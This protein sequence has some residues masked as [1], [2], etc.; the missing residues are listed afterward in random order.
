MH[1]LE[2]PPVENCPLNGE[3]KKRHQDHLFL[4]PDDRHDMDQKQKKRSETKQ[5]VYVMHACNLFVCGCGCGC[6]EQTSLEYG[7]G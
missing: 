5:V 1:L 6:L 2:D 7:F 3:Y 4:W